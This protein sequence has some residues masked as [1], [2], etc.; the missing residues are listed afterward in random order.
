MKKILITGGAGNIGGSLAKRLVE[1]DDNF[2]V[3]VDNMLTGDV[4]K[5]P[6]QKENWKFIKCDV[7]N[8]KDISAVMLAYS[9]D[10][11]FHY[12]AVVGVQRTL[13]NPILVLNDID[14][15]RNV[16]N[17]SKNTGVKRIFYSSSSEVY[18]EP[19]ESPQNELTTPL[20]SRLP[21]AIVKNLGEA[22]FRSFYQEYGLEFTIF[23][24][25][26]TYGPMQSV[27][28]VISK[29]IVAALNNQPITIYGDGSQTRTFCY[30][31]DNLDM[32]IKTWQEG[33]FINDVV[34]VGS[35]DE[36]SVLSMAQL[37]VNVLNSKSEI[38][39]LPPLK[40]G[41][42]ARRKPDV[43]KMRKVLG[44]ELVSLKE[45]IS[46]VAAFLK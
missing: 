8:Y 41:D 17:L 23:R 35:D 26:N 16:L 9:F 33:H 40:E 3:I 36:Q 39:H 42:M 20:N 31:S 13:A 24:F 15:I 28:F 46:R 29:F 43:T 21:Y 10:Y 7:N 25:F 12:A 32:T 2:V 14:G 18:G 34:N 22:Y 45:G 11:V 5:L 30:I 19:V 4:S 37:V 6:L 44:R 38:V 1:D 27:D